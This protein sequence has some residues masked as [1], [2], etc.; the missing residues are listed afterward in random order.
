MLPP[1]DFNDKLSK[2]VDLFH[3]LS[4]TTKDLGVIM[5]GEI[6]LHL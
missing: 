3:Y 6:L 4:S 5:Y 1:A 2:S